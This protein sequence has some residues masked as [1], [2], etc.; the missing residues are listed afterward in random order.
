MQQIDEFST[1]FLHKALPNSGL[2]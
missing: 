1:V 2:L